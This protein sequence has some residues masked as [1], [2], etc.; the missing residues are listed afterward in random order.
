MKRRAEAERAQ[1][2]ALRN[3]GL[4]IRAIAERLGVPSRTVGGWLRGRGDC[5][6]VRTCELCGEP[7]I[8]VS[9]RHRFCTPAH[10]R[11]HSYV[12]G[13]G[14]VRVLGDPAQARQIEL[15]P[16]HGRRLGVATVEAEAA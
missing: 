8:A 13:A 15:P 2:L 4:S 10:Q 6:A 7:F 9:A 14:T 11:K 5:H 16:L 3:E 12:F 1:A